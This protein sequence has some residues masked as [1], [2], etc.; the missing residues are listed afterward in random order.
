M[1]RKSKRIVEGKVSAIEGCLHEMRY[2]R[3]G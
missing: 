1:R 2:D 3:L